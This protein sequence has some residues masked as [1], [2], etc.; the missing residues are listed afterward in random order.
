MSDRLTDA[1]SPQEEA[2]FDPRRV[3][4]RILT[5]SSGACVNATRFIGHPADSGLSHAT[6]T[7]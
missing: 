6:T 5:R 1:V 2:L 4:A 3:S 7:F